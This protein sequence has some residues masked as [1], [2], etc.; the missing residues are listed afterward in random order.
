MIDRNI[1][2]IVMME[3]GLLR[4]FV[5]VVEL[6]LALSREHSVSR[7]AALAALAITPLPTSAVVAGRRVLGVE[8]GLPALPDL[9]FAIFERKRSDAAASA[10]AA[11]LVS[12]GQTVVRP[13]IG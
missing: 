1:V 7:A 12:L 5:A 9:E 4:S 10:L 8:S 2:S 6:P 11:V 3:F 13:P